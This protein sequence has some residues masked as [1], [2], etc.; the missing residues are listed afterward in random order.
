MARLLNNIEQQKNLAIELNTRLM[1]MIGSG[2][3]GEQVQQ[4]LVVLKLVSNRL[5]DFYQRYD[6]ILTPTV[7]TPP[8][9]VWMYL[10]SICWKSR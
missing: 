1:A 3:R 10:I 8:L 2:I 7:A 4:A 9:R 6:V 5:S